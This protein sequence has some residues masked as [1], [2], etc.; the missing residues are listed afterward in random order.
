MFGTRGTSLVN[1]RHKLESKSENVYFVG[2]NRERKG[3][4]LLTVNGVEIYRRDV[5]LDETA[6]VDW[7]LD[8]TTTRNDTNFLPADYILTTSHDAFSK[9]IVNDL[10]NGEGNN[11]GFD[12]DDNDEASKHENTD[13]VPTLD[14]NTTSDIEP[15][16]TPRKNTFSPVSKLRE[17]PAEEKKVSNVAP[18]RSQRI[19]H[20][21]NEIPPE[22][23]HTTMTLHNRPRHRHTPTSPRRSRA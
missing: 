4:M 15:D 1:E 2:F 14:D 13:G 19:Q 18:R 5:R 6:L 23:S 22:T 16:S 10:E 8:P 9:P 21:L 20:S 3:Y 17:S 7:N 12:D 11:K